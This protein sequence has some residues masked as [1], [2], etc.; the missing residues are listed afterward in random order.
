MREGWPL[1]AL[2]GSGS[3]SSAF[4]VKGTFNRS[5]NRFLP[6]KLAL[7]TRAKALTSAN[8]QLCCGKQAQACLPKSGCSLIGDVKACKRRIVTTGFARSQRFQGLQEPWNCAFGLLRL[9]GVFAALPGR[10]ALATA[11]SKRAL[12]VLSCGGGGYGLKVRCTARKAY[13][14]CEERRYRPRERERVGR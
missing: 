1:G 3:L 2:S 11:V 10:L 12:W 13:D 4:A 8:R 14:A 6:C 7:S 9:C 5:W